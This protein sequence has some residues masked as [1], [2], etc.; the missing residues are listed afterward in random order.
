L[1]Q[2]ALVFDQLGWPQF[3]TG[4]LV[5]EQIVLRWTH[6]T[7]GIIWIGLLYFFNFVATP[8]MKELEPGARGKI[9]PALMTRA[10][11]WF[12][13]S[14]LVTVL[15]G[16]RYFWQMLLVDATNDGNATLAGRWLGEWAGV[17]L[18]AYALIYL[19][20]MPRR[21]LLDN[22]WV[23]AT[24]IGTVTLLAMYVVL[25]LNANAP[26]SNNH[27]AI[28][29]G[30]GLGLL[31]LLNAWG[32]MW[33]AQKRLIFWTTENFERGTPMP[34]RAEYLARWSFRASR[35]SFWMSFPMLFFMAAAG[36]YP[37]LFSV[38]N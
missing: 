5:N 18:A 13:W 22:V 12:R 16:L 2:V 27:L 17:W 34:K 24:G 36:H 14:A 10:M 35:V 1:V 31:M 11:W 23:R 19:L 26:A 37:F 33:R 30:G 20:Q 7:A 6:I 32:V 3:P 8:A 38:S 4:M 9:Y 21:G 25:Y 15:A 29:A 28:A